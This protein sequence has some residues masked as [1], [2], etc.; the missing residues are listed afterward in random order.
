M[1]GK[2]EFPAYLSPSQ[3]NSLTTCGM[4]YVL[5]RGERVPER[6]TMG[7]VGGGAVHTLT[8]EIDRTGR[9]WSGEE[10]YAA[11][12]AHLEQSIAEAEKS[13]FT[14]DQFY[15]GGRPSARWPNRENIDWWN[16]QGPLF[17][18]QW[19]EWLATAGWEV[20]DLLDQST[21]EVIPG[22]EVEVTYRTQ[23]G[24]EVLSYIDRVVRNKV[25]GDHAVV[26][27]K[28][29]SMTPP[30]PLQM[31]YNGWGL[32]QCYDVLPRWS[33]YWKARKG[34]VESWFDMDTML[35]M[36]FIDRQ[37]EVANEIKKNELFMAVPSNLCANAC[38]VKQ[39][40]PVYKTPEVNPSESE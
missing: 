29:G 20:A 17:V 2:Y 11:W 34:T 18:A 35:Q 4:Q 16:H 3:I 37:A 6:P 19:Q 28:T 40:C 12:G 9:T 15:C 5:T 13:G 1:S 23:S 7:G 33:G 22:I 25:S 24:L 26:D 31:A 38:G 36:E 32:Y 27:L 8:E 10:I 14:L 39:Y 21:G 30:W